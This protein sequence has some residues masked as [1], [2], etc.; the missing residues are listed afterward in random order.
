MSHLT[1]PFL[2][3]R[4]VVNH[5]NIKILQPIL[6]KDLFLTGGKT[7]EIVLWRKKDYIYVP[8]LLMLPSL[9]QGA[10]PLTAITWIKLPEPDLLVRMKFMKIN[11]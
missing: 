2:F 6:S 1:F 11:D 3:K 9:N 7:G 5:H 4:N 10:G 8:N